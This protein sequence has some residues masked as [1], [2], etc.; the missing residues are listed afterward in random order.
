MAPRGAKANLATFAA[1]PPR[2]LELHYD[3]NQPGILLWEVPGNGVC[4]GRADHSLDPGGGIDN[5]HQ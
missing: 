4:D 2:E 1:E 5:A 3:R